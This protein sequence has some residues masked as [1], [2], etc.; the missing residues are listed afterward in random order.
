MYVPPPPTS[1][2]HAIHYRQLTAK[3][4]PMSKSEEI[5]MSAIVFTNFHAVF[6]FLSETVMV[7]R[8]QRIKYPRGRMPGI[9][10]RGHLKACVFRTGCIMRILY[11]QVAFKM[12][13]GVTA[14]VASWNGDGTAFSLLL[15]DNPLIGG[16]CMFICGVFI[17]C[18]Y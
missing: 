5:F 11:V 4:E 12:F 3:G 6:C 8:G 10:A 14:D 7:H 18:V 9:F 2:L 15:Y 17:A 16:L 1:P 13:L